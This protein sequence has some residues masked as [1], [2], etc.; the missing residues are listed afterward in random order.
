MAKL[1]GLFSVLAFVVAMAIVG[2]QADDGCNDDFRNM[3]YEC[4]QYVMFPANTKIPP[5][6]GCCGV[7]QKANVPCLCYKVTKEI[8]KLVCM[9]KVVYVA[10]YCKKPL[11][12]GSQCGSYTVPGQ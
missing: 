10:D 3:V 9:D 8:E 6:D 5:S 4:K 11:Q 1:L 12:P 7:I 2:T